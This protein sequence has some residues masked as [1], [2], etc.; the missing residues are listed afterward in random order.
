MFLGAD[1]ELFLGAVVKTVNSFATVAFRTDANDDGNR[2][3]DT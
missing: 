1:H 2:K 3:K